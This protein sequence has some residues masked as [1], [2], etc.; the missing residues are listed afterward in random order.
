[1]YPANVLSVNNIWNKIYFS[2]I[3]TIFIK[4]SDPERSFSECFIHFKLEFLSLKGSGSAN[5]YIDYVAIHGN[6]YALKEI[7]EKE[8]DKKEEEKQDKEKKEKEK[9]EKEKEEKE[10]REKEKEM[11]EKEKKDKGK[12][13]NEKEKKKGLRKKKKRK[14]KM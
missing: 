11:E 10:K 1:M 5:K 3:P 7:L 8:R 13:E 2:S 9:K 12:K 14:Q 4:N 6:E